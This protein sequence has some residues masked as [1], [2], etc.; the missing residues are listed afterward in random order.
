MIISVDCLWTS[1]ISKAH[2]HF[3]QLHLPL[4]FFT[5]FAENYVAQVFK[6]RNKLDLTKMSCR[7]V[8]DCA[9]IQ[10][11]IEHSEILIL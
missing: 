9:F 8:V 10:D 6:K 2:F 7:A 4:S 11:K 5:S 1:R 3:K